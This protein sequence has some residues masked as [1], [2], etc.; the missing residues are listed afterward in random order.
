MSSVTKVT[1]LIV[2][3]TPRSI[4]NLFFI[5]Q[6][7]Q[8]RKFIITTIKRTVPCFSTNTIS[9]K[10]SNNLSS[11]TVKLLVHNISPS[12]TI[13]RMLPW[14][15]PNNSCSINQIIRYR[16]R[17]SMVASSTT[18]EARKPFHTAPTT[19]KRS[20]RTTLAA[21]T[22]KSHQ[23]DVVEPPAPT[24]ITSHRRR[25]IPTTS[26]VKTRALVCNSH[27]ARLRT[28]ISRNSNSL[29][30]NRSTQ[31]SSVSLSAKFLKVL[32]HQECKS[33]IHLRSHI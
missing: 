22:V 29:R 10:I 1:R 24:F 6:V 28:L 26:P 4:E 27:K 30:P 21:T 20:N 8:R 13:S 17:D 15:I 31:I 18:V 5:C 12:T 11:K 2:Q 14:I 3:R 16:H 32:M 25:R 9:N 19:R 33:I 23:A 7:W